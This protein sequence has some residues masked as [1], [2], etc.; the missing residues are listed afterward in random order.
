MNFREYNA[1]KFLLFIF[2]KHRND[3][4]ILYSET[5]YLFKIIYYSG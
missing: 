5:K 4:L 2:N 3:S 1:N